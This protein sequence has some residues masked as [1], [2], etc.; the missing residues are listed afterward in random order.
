MKASCRE[1][2]FVG[3]NLIRASV[4]AAYAL[5]ERGK[6]KH[7]RT[8]IGNARRIV[9]NIRELCPHYSSVLNRQIHRITT[10]V[11]RHPIM[12]GRR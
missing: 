1:I 11:A 10:F 5:A 6:M 9:A 3:R 8:A 12:S 2:A 4:D 7:A